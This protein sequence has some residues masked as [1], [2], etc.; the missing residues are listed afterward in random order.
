MQV[1]SHCLNPKRI[2]N[3]YTKRYEYVA[4]NECYACRNIRT[5]SLCHRVEHEIKTHHYSLF[6]TLTYDNDSLPRFEVIEDK[7]GRKQIRP[8]GRLADSYDRYP[9]VYSRYSDN[10]KL[11][12]VDDVF[13]PYIQNDDCLNEFGVCSKYDIQCFL[14]RI[15]KKLSKI[16][17]DKNSRTFRYFIASEYGPV[18][19][20]PH[21]HGI[22]FFDSEELLNSFPSL[23]A[24]S[25]GLYE[26]RPGSRNNFV[27]RPFARPALT[28]SYIKL[29]D[30][31]TARYVASYV[32][33]ND[34]LP[35]VLQTSVTQTFALYSQ[36]PTFGSYKADKTK[37]LED[38]SYGV[39]K[40]DSITYN[41]NGE[42][43]FTRVPYSKSDLCSVFRKCRGYRDLSP[44]AK[45]L[46]Y[47][48]VADRCA[49]WKELVIRLSMY[50][51]F[52]SVKKFLNKNREFTLR[53][54][55]S[56]DPLYSALGMDD[57]S[58]WF[59]SLYCHKMIEKYPIFRKLGF[60]SPVDAYLYLFSQFEKLL[61]L[62]RYHDF[63][64]N[65]NDWYIRAGPSSLFSAYPFL[66]E[67]L[68]TSLRYS[69]TLPD[70]YR[71]LLKNSGL[72][73]RLYDARGVLDTCY[74]DSCIEQNSNVFLNFKIDSYKRFQNRLKS[75][76]ANN[77]VFA[78]Y[79]KID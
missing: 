50:D 76:K 43:E 49:E 35:K 10:H 4:C 79:R 14:K 1:F 32:A 70:S 20:R 34:C 29:C 37:M 61:E 11:L 6:F 56:N 73:K 5:S 71:S 78:N 3:R 75:K 69:T 57:D 54:Y 2:F 25:W 33:G 64:D 26:R 52:T 46:I 39:V 23:I 48:F 63:I 28:R 13:A 8:C 59:A 41:K 31:G 47:S 68:P 53:N 74:V 40:Y 16:Y 27:F 42:V 55:L 65:L 67:N 7:K 17:H 38:V 45:S 18:T 9:L 15:R 66:S 51:G 30:V 60:A 44:Y 19:L 36:A 62:S 12:H 24:D 22:F 21:Y 58:T 72:M 77:K